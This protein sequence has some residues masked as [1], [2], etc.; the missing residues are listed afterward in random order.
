M[1]PDAIAFEHVVAGQRCEP[2]AIT[3]FDDSLVDVR[4]ARK[5]GM[6]AHH[7]VAYA[8]LVAVLEREGIR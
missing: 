7:T 2:A 5:V 6:I 4:A 8:E 1:K 3:F